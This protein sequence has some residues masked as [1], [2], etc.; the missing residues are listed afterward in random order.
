MRLE[1]KVP[2][3][4]SDCEIVMLPVDGVVVETA[5]RMLHSWEEPSIKVTVI[6]DTLTRERATSSIGTGE[7][8][9]GG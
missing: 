5:A 4:E 6:G 3:V 1:V 2:P 9:E 7:A 8:V